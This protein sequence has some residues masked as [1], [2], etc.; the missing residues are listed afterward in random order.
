MKTEIYQM[1]N[2]F[3]LQKKH[4]GGVKFVKLAWKLMRISSSNNCLLA[5]VGETIRFAILFF[6]YQSSYSVNVLNFCFTLMT[7]TND[8]VN[9]FP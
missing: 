9:F 7:D 6:I 8:L 2:I 4:G 3:N 1:E 5:W